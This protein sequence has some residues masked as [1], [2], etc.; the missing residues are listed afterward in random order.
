MLKQLWCPEN[1]RILVCVDTYEN[2]VPAGRFSNCL[3]ETESF[4]SLSQLLIRIEAMLD[5]QH[6]PQ[7]YTTHRTFAA[8][9]DQLEEE[10]PAVSGK[11]CCATFELKILFRQHGSWQGTVIWKER[12]QEHSFRSVL[13]LVHLLDSALRSLDGKGVA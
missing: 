8:V 13:E 2:C 12:R 10:P 11:G 5:D 1:N 3:Q 6:A 7:S 9:M 4:S